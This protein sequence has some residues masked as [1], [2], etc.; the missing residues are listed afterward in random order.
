VQGILPAVQPWPVAPG[1]RLTT[2]MMG[3][4]GRRCPWRRCLLGEEQAGDDEDSKAKPV[5]AAPRKYAKMASAHCFASWLQ[6]RL[7][8]RGSQCDVRGSM[9]IGGL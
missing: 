2:T 3:A 4:Q 9:S 1:R 5:F 6:A 8:G 7:R